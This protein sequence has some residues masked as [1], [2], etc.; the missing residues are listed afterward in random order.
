[1][2]ISD[3][4]KS[5]RGMG[6]AGPCRVL[7]NRDGSGMMRGM[8][9]FFN[10]AGP[11]IPG[12]HYLL[13]SERRCADLLPLIEQNQYFV[14]HAARQTGK[15]TLLKSIVSTLNRGGRY[16]A[17]Y[18][19]V[20][21]LRAAPQPQTG[22][23]SLLHVLKDDLQC[24]PGMET[25]DFLEGIDLADP[26]TALRKALHQLARK[27][28]KP[29]VI[30]FDEA[31]SLREDLL[32]CFLTQLRGGYIGR[33]TAAFPQS[34]ALVGMRD[35][36]DYKASVRE[37]RKRL[38]GGSPFNIVTESLTLRNFSREETAELYGQHTADTGQVFE[39]DAV[40]FVFRQTDGQPWLVNAVARECIEKIL[41]RDF[42]KPVTGE[43]VEQAIQNI[44]LRRDT[45]IDSL[46][47]KL[48]EERV[49][50]IVEPV[51]T[52]D[53]REFNS[54]DD[55]CRY[56]LDLG[57]LKNDREG[58]CPANPIYAEVMIRM[59]SLLAQERMADMQLST[60]L[61]RYSQGGGLDMKKLLKDFQAFWRE[62]A[63][64]MGDASDYR[65]AVPH[66]VLQA[67]LQ[68]ILNG[69]GRIHREFAVGRRRMDLLIEW[70]KGRY[71]LEI[72]LWRGEKTEEEGL[73]Q[74]GNYLERVN[75]P[76]GWLV[77]FDRRPERSWDEKIFWREA[78]SKNR[79]I[80][81][82]GC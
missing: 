11:C 7:P 64:M 65:E 6:H 68:R 22:I 56:A 75:C 47:E 8:G 30:F 63:E 15:T 28:G 55:D 54:A 5:A 14:I 38:G 25:F 46:I 66:L 48:K 78:G 18:S 41:Q 10:V 76:E 24:L 12:E 4:K 9:R 26:H 27:A 35:L 72:K 40:D 51:L 36:R 45:H 61:A 58:L 59:L 31:D 74:L 21:Q 43:L 33:D 32:I 2:E 16:L 23:P 79:K 39:P 62:N 29:T 80:H 70:E 37:G 69:G 81:I 42:S 1:M 19:S 53:K 67:F 44:I 57:L 73:A 71:P 82:A 77:L 13:P 52:G 20:E 60:P 3:L 34:I 17:I 49:R 50:K